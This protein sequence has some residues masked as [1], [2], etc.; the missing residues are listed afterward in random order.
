MLID[1]RALSDVLLSLQVT[2]G[3]PPSAHRTCSLP[4]A[5]LPSPP[6][7]LIMP[8]SPSRPLISTPLPVPIPQLP[9]SARLCSSLLPL[10]D[11]SSLLSLT[12]F[13]PYVCSPPSCPN[14]TSRGHASLLS[15]S[16]LSTSILLSRCS[17]KPRALML[18]AMSTLSL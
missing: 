1:L 11:K 9:L 7:T 15:S 16:Q 13:S 3:S 18:P 8:P 17:I 10:Y 5:L 6:H 2:R 14:P 12:A 4:H